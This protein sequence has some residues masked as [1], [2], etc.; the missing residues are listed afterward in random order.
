MFVKCLK[1]V[2]KF[3]DSFMKKKNTNFN[4]KKYYPSFKKILTFIQKNTIRQIAQKVPL[5]LSRR[6]LGGSAKILRSTRGNRGT[7][8]QRR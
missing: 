4:S 6:G 3:N 8:G 2:C 1:T 7:V 5:R